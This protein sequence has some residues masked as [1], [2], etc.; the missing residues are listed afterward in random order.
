MFV[1]LSFL[2]AGQLFAQDF[3]ILTE[4][5]APF[6]FST[7]GNVKGIAVDLLIEILDGTKGTDIKVVPW[8]RAYQEAQNKPGTLLFSMGRTESR[9]N[10]FKWV[11]PIYHLQLG[12]I[13]KKSNGINISS[14]DDF[15][16]YNIG[17]VRESAPEQLLLKDG[18]SED[19][20]DRTASLESNLKKLLAGRVDAIAFNIPS[21]LYN[22]KKMGANLDDYEVIY[23][24]KNLD[25]YY[26]FHKDTDDS[27]INKSQ[28]SLEKLKENGRYDELI[29][30]Y[31]K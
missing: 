15:N 22:L 14:A 18:A 24:L 17:T 16:K 29:S 13:A 5:N 21:A 1:C 28:L 27:F 10:L 30:I 23:V 31:L 8:A 6:N 7:D 4:E 19:N 3:N 25:L 11:G 2:T 26:A 12:L 20:L 9:E